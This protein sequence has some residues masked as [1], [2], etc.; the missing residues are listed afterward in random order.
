MTP[1]SVRTKHYSSY[2]TAFTTIHF[3]ATNT[4]E[5][6]RSSH[7]IYFC[8]CLPLIKYFGTAVLTWYT[9]SNHAAKISY[10][11]YSNMSAT[12]K[13]VIN[14][15]TFDVPNSYICPITRQVM[16]RPFKTPSGEH[17]E[18]AAI[19]SWL[20]VVG[21][22]PLTLT[23]LQV[24]DLTPNTYLEYL[25][26]R[27]RNN[28]G[29]SLDGNNEYL[30]SKHSEVISCFL[31]FSSKEE[32]E[33]IDQQI[34]SIKLSSWTMSGGTR[35]ASMFSKPSEVLCQVVQKYSASCSIASASYG[36][37]TKKRKT[38]TTTFILHEVCSHRGSDLAVAELEAILDPDHKA[39]S[40]P[41]LLTKI[42]KVYNPTA[43]KV[44]PKLVSEPTNTPLNLAISYK[45]SLDALERLVEA[46]P[47][48]L[49]MGDNKSSALC[50]F[51]CGM[52]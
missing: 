23:P 33:N 12:T 14:N 29:L 13:V 32:E 35:I 45:A 49:S 38:S 34:N 20:K 27:W 44:E 4:T 18:R 11:F 52:A 31:S 1:R 26:K 10:F 39:A 50:T 17:F 9:Q 37:A 15:M 43:G 3:T 7:P 6:L 21:T 24:S 42:K 25:I 5:P 2:C 16:V 47:Q 28:N 19:L 8:P 48:V 40:R 41:V 51:C 46:A 36:P 22:C 30:K